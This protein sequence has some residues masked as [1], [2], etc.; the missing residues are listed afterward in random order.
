MTGQ[1]GPRERQGKQVGKNERED[2]LSGMTHRIRHDTI[3]GMNI[4]LHFW[5]IFALLSGL[6]LAGRNVLMKTATGKIDPALAAMVLSVS[7]AVVSV[8]FLI[9]QRLSKSEPLIGG[10]QADMAGIAIALIAGV[11]LAA[12]NIFL[13][14]SY[15]EGGGAGVVAILQNGFSISL[16]LLVGALFLSEIIKPQQMVGIALA[17]A[18]IFL[19]VKK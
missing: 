2:G 8:G 4:A 17:M 11:S 9:W 6:G 5:W 14:Y 15:K 16:T 19:I 1:T 12:A 13:V 7:M 3:S 10:G 18:G